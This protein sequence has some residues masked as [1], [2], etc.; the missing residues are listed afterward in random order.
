MIRLIARIA[1]L[2]IALAL[3]GCGTGES[4]DVNVVQRQQQTMESGSPVILLRLE[5]A[6]HD[7]DIWERVAVVRDRKLV[8]LTALSR[9]SRIACD[10]PRSCRVQLLAP[11]SLWPR[12]YQ[13]EPERFLQPDNEIADLNQIGRGLSVP[14]PV[15]KTQQGHAGF[16]PVASELAGEAALVATFV[17]RQVMLN[18]QIAGAALIATSFCF[19]CCAFVSFLLRRFLPRTAL[20][21]GLKRWPCGRTVPLL[22]YVAAFALCISPLVTAFGDGPGAVAE[23]RPEL[24]VPVIYLLGASPLEPLIDLMLA[25]AGVAL[26]DA[27]ARAVRAGSLAASTATQVEADA[28]A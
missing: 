13:L 9:A 26:F 25:L 27:L 20:V 2:C 24:F 3:A 17:K 22:G 28:D 7:S 1:W 19:V 10:N 12:S 4:G 21:R 18:W 14:I 15:D 6:T 8:G 5:V 16:E 23:S 11:G